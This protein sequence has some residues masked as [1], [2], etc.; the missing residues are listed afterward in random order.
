EL[1]ILILFLVYSCFRTRASGSRLKAQGRVHTPIPRL[2]LFPLRIFPVPM[3]VPGSETRIPPK[4]NVLLS[5]L[6]FTQPPVAPI[7]RPAAP[8]PLMVADFTDALE[9]L[10][11]M[12]G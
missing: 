5:V 7:H 9:P 10:M 1:A 4:L 12:T 8:C 6:S 2:L 3:S 11:A